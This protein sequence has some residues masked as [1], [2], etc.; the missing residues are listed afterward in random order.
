MRQY[1]MLGR[2]WD[3]LKLTKHKHLLDGE[4]RSFGLGRHIILVCVALPLEDVEETHGGLGVS[5]ERSA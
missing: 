5:G 2:T 1:S 3:R 4:G